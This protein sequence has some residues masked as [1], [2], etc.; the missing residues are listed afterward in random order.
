MATFSTTGGSFFGDGSPA[1]NSY[2]FFQHTLRYTLSGVVGDLNYTSTYTNT[3]VS[4]VG[5]AA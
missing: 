4:G 2:S 1:L 5:G 3:L